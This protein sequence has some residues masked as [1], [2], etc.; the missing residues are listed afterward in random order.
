MSNIRQP[1]P[2]AEHALVRTLTI[3][4]SSGYRWERHGSV[5]G[6]LVWASFGV[7][8]VTVDAMVWVVPPHQALWIPSHLS[9]AVQLAGR[10]T[11]RQV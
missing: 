2:A 3:G 9:H 1:S 5:W 11:L 4:F 8:T 6:V 7:I 10:G